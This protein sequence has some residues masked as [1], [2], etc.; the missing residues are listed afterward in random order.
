MKKN[1]R[2]LFSLFLLLFC[3]SKSYSQGQ[4]TQAKSS[5][6]ETFGGANQ[7]EEVVQKAFKTSYNKETAK[8]F[9]GAIKALKEVYAE[10]SYEINLR[11]G[12]LYYQN[13]LNVESINYYTKA[14]NLRPNSIEAKLGFT[15]PQSALNHWEE[16]IGAY[17]EVLA[18][19]EYKT[20]ALFNL[21]TIYF[22]NK[23]YTEAAKYFDKLYSIYP[24][25][26]DALN[27]LAKTMMQMGKSEE[28]TFYFQKAL[29]ISPD[30]ASVLEGLKTLNTK[31]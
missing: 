23:N 22:N 3:L 27:M 11:L 2:Y 31:K 21:G 14:M 17:K 26:F 18:I 30:N 16:V 15:Y 6:I 20:K 28:A 8:D 29:L 10:T 5:K 7:S 1:M 24:F 13:G 25:D 4:N 9:E 12:W 19:E